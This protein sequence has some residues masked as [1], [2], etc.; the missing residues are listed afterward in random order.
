[1]KLD[2]TFEHLLNVLKDHNVDISRA[3]VAQS[4][5]DQGCEEFATWIGKSLNQQTLLSA[6]E[7]TL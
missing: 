2:S 6:D 1:M 3:E 4:L 5:G 7:A